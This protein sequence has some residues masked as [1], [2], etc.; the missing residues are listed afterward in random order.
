VSRAVLGALAVD[1]GRAGPALRRAH[2]DHGPAR[3]LEIGVLRG[4]RLDL[5]DLVERLVEE[6]REPGVDR[7]VVLVV[8]TGLEDVRLVAVAG[9][10]SDELFF[11]D[12]REHR[13]VR[14][15]VAVQVQDRQD[16]AV[17]DGIDELVGVP[18]GRERPGL[19]LAVADDG[20]DE[21]VG[22][23][24]RGAVGVGE[25][26]A[27]LAALV[28]RAGRLGGDVRGDAAGE[29]ELREEALQAF[30]VV[31]DVVVRLGVGPVEERR[32]DETR[33][34]VPGADDVHRGLQAPRDRAVEV[35]VDEVEARRRAPVPD[36][37]RLDVVA[38]QR[39]AQQRIVEQVDL[40]D[41]HV[42]GGAPPP[43]DRLDIGGRDARGAA[44]PGRR[45]IVSAHIVECGTARAVATGGRP[46][47]SRRSRRAAG[48]RL[49]SRAAGR[50][51]RGWM[52][53]RR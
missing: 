14:D 2:D 7:Q 50:A 30:L 13:R 36:E 48:L 32:R 17:G 23:V 51:L 1:L 8:E 15:L 28:D 29:G 33:P 5:R 10:E 25:R 6:R 34:A 52:P 20:R 26:V 24:E 11:G 18:A 9:H 42:V 46:C 31:R 35:G 16:D 43:V 44:G 41:A 21:Q 49:V 4:I 37:A 39:L 12:A 40:P 22:V 45:R 38:G 27:E 53:R 19:G 3:T 47:K